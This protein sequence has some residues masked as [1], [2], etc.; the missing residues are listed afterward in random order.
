MLKDIRDIKG[1]RVAEHGRCPLCARPGFF[2]AA[3]VILLAA[4][5]LTVLPYLLGSCGLVYLV[6]SAISIVLVVC[7][8]QKPPAGAI[9]F[10]YAEVALIT[11]G[12]MADLLVYGP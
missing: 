1:D 11:A 3:K 5:L 7:S 10:I 2:V 9:P 8:L 4:A 6:S 12:S